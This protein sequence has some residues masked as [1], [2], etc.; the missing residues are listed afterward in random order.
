MIYDCFPFFN[1]LNILD[2]RLNVLDDVVVKFVLVESTKTFIGKDKPLYYKDNKHLFEKF[3][4]KIIHI[5]VDDCPDTTDG[6]VMQ[7]YQRNAI[8]RGLVGCNDDDVILIS[9]LDE[10]PNPQKIIEYKD[11]PGIKAFRQV[12]FY[13]FLN[14]LVSDSWHRVKMLSYKDFKSILDNN[15]CYAKDD[16]RRDLSDKTTADKIRWHYT[17]DVYFIGDGGWHFSYVMSYDKILTKIKMFSHFESTSV[18]D[19]NIDDIAGIV[20]VGA[21]YPIKLTYKNLPKYIVDNQDKFKEF[22]LPNAKYDIEDIFKTRS[23]LVT[24]IAKKVSWWIPIR[25]LREKFRRHFG[26]EQI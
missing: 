21:K 1:E 3:N 6:W 23:D 19:G 18:Y 7:T 2:I 16:P 5:I 24:T 10:I 12:M 20:E 9:D 8:E 11:K 14:N 25:S 4:D 26:V 15:N 13:Y 22:I 17:N